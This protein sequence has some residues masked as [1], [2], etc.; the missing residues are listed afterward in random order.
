VNF[1]AFAARFRM[2]WRSFPHVGAKGDGPLGHL[3]HEAQLLGG[4]ERLHHRRSVA[5]QRGE[6][7]LADAQLGAPRLL[8]RE[9]EDLLDQPQQVVARRADAPQL[10][11]AARR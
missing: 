9:G 6:I 4:G 7:H 11:A 10:V 5:H 3:Q 8:P 2:I 1:T